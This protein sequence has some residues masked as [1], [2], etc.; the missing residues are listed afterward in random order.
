[1]LFLDPSAFELTRLHEVSRQGLLLPLLPFDPAFLCLPSSV[2]M[3]CI[4]L[5]G[6]EYFESA[7]VPLMQNRRGIFIPDVTVRIDFQSRIAAATAP[8]GSFIC[9]SV[10]QGVLSRPAGY[11]LDHQRFI[12][13]NGQVQAEQ[14][15]I[16]R[17]AFPLWQIGKVIDGIWLG[18]F[19][20]RPTG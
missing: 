14:E 7:P 15:G 11:E 12:A 4:A 10:A 9:T 17:A 19:D 20:V 2:E 13:L 1:M 18:L 16:V 3:N 6:A 5:N 8:I